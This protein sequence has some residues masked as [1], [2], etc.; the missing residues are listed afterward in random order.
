MQE[1]KK[2]IL[3]PLQKLIGSDFNPGLLFIIIKKSFI[4]CVLIVLITMSSSLLYLRYTPPLYEVGSTLMIKPENTSKAIGL[5]NIGLEASRG[6]ADLQRDIQVMKSNLIMDRVLDKLPL[7]VSYYNTGQILVEEKYKS[8]P[9]EILPLVKTNSIYDLPINF[10][11]INNKSFKIS[12]RI[13]QQKFIYNGSYGKKIRTP[14]FDFTA[15]TDQEVLKSNIESLKTGQFYFVINNRQTVAK[16]IRD[17]IRINPYTPSILISFQDKN[18]YRA[19]DIVNAMNDEFISYDKE[20]KTESATLILNFI[21]SQINL[22][23]AELQAYENQIKAF[24]IQNGLISTESKISEILTAL[25]NIKQKQIMLNIKDNM[26]YSYQD[27]FNRYED[28]TRLFSGIV[29]VQFSALQE[30]VRMLDKLQADKRYFLLSKTANNPEVINIEKQIDDLKLNIKENIGNTLKANQEER[31]AQNEELTKYT[32]EF[33]KFPELEAE[34]ARL[35]KISD[36]KEKYYLLLLDKKSGF[37]ISLAGF[38]SDFLILKKAEPP[39]SP[40]FPNVPLIKMIGIFSGIVISLLFIIIR[41]LLSSKILSPTEVERNSRAGLIGVIPI[42]RKPMDVSQLVVNMNPKSIISESFRSIRTNLEYIPLD[43]QSDKRL[44]AVTSTIAGEGKTFIAVNTAGIYSVAGKKTIILDFD[45][46][47]PRIHKAF[48]T[49]NNKGISTILIG[50]YTVEECIKHSEWENLDYITSGPIPPNPAEFIMSQQTKDLIEYLK[51]KYDV[52]VIDTPP[53]GVVTDALELMK[54]ADY[55]IYVVRADYSNRNF[56]NN[57]NRL[58][59]DNKINRLSV[60]INS[61][62][63]GASGYSYSYGYNYGYG[64]GYGY[65]GA[66]GG[67]YGGYG[68]GYGYGGYTYG[69]GYYSDTNPKPKTFWDKIKNFFN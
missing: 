64:Y 2:I 42:Y 15:N 48:A 68:Y 6:N 24:K 40:V 58:V 32:N 38:V 26:L 59:T 30:F 31:K 51:T 44:I 60:V 14:H 13:G 19:A 52:V 29:D 27:Y 34:F 61:M 50:K 10:E 1:E 5:D 7:L 57:V 4:W 28:S 69:Y 53:I 63:S 67:S 17:V 49:E 22:I 45:L 33:N 46:R 43:H 9:F 16:R 23:N 20:K 62:G 54:R 11:F 39:L 12:Y 36:L 8:S 66:Y 3:S 55:P 35:R 25:N 37:S 41:Y 21:E 47:K 65:G 18:P 56:L